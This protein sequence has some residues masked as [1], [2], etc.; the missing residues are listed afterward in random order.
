MCRFSKLLLFSFSSV[1]MAVIDWWNGPLSLVVIFFALCLLLLTWSIAGVA[2]RACHSSGTFFLLRHTQNALT[3]IH[4]G[5]PQRSKFDPK[6]HKIV[7]KSHGCHVR[8][9]STFWPGVDS[10]CNFYSRPA[11]M[12]C[13]QN[14]WTLCGT[15]KVTVLVQHG[16]CKKIV[17][18]ETLPVRDPKKQEGLVTHTNWAAFFK[19]QFS[20]GCGLCA[21]WV[22]I[23][24]GFCS[25]AV[26]SNGISLR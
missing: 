21:T 23:K 13:L 25:S 18:E 1:R 16:E 26:F 9:F 10:K 24:C 4:W 3:H 19:L 14:L 15:L 7:Y 8:F 6:R 5:T 17:C 22:W 2:C 12:Q 11:Y 20:F